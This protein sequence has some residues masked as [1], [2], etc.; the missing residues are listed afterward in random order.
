L[1]RRLDGG[2]ADVF[3]VEKRYVHKNGT[4]IWARTT[5]NVIGDEFGRS[6]RRTAVIQDLSARKQAEQALVLCPRRSN[7]GWWQYDPIH[8]VAW[9]IHA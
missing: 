2:E 7:L 5:V 4:V 3:D 1:A 9:W 8:R 6:L